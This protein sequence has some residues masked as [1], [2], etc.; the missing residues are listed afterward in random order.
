MIGELFGWF[1]KASK[2]RKLKEVDLKK[3]FRKARRRYVVK[4]GKSPGIL[5]VRKDEYEGWMDNM[6]IDVEQVDK[7][8]APNHF[9]LASEGISN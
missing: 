2:I 9:M 7:N 8:L 3:I 1:E 5:V 6:G 4:H